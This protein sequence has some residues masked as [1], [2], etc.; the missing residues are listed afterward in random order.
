MGQSLDQDASGNDI[1]DIA[2]APVIVG[3][4]D[5][6]GGQS[7]PCYPQREALLWVGAYSYRLDNAEDPV[8]KYRVSAQGVNNDGE[9]VGWWCEFDG[10]DT[11]AMYWQDE[12]A[13]PVVLG[14]LPLIPSIAQTQAEAIND[15]SMVVGF[16]E[17]SDIA[18]LWERDGSQWSWSD[19]N[20]IAVAY[21][22]EG[23]TPPIWELERGWDINDNAWIVGSGEIT[24]DD[25]DTERAFLL[26]PDFCDGDLNDDG[27]VNVSDLTILLGMWGHECEPVGD[28]CRPDINHDR[29]V[30]VSDLQILL[31]AWGP[32]PEERTGSERVPP[33]LLQT[34][35]AIGGEYALVSGGITAEQVAYCMNRE[36]VAEIMAGLFDLISE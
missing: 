35:L 16:N 1:A 2:D 21:Y 28:V 10:Y 14:H 7:Q 18:V 19:L 25:N 30:N 27:L 17:T 24:I 6:C 22:Y 11:R 29:I 34:W 33:E 12:T 32:C 36:S 15:T 4:R 8:T 3:F 5:G 9:I 23:E 13:E 20:D 31:G 26:V